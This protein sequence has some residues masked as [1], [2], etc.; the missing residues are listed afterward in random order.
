MEMASG[1]QFTVLSTEKDDV[2]IGHAITV[3]DWIDLRDGYSASTKRWLYFKRKYLWE[4]ILGC[5]LLIPACP[6]I[7]LLCIL[8]RLNSKGNALY[9]QTRVGFRGKT[10]EIY[11][12][13]TMRCD[14]E[15]DGEARWCQKNDERITPLGRIIRKLHLDE[16]P[17]LFNVAQGDMT[18][19][20]PRPERPVF[21]DRLKL[22]ISGYER[23]LSVLPG[24]T[25]LAQINLPPD[26][27]TSDVRRKLY[28]DL[29]YIDGACFWLDFRML[30][31]SSVRL[32][33]VPGTIVTHLLGLY[34]PAPV[35]H[36]PSD[37][38]HPISLHP[39]SA[40]IEQPTRRILKNRS[41]VTT[42]RIKFARQS[43]DLP[44]TSSS[45][46]TR[47]ADAVPN[48]LTVDVEDY[49]QVSAFEHRIARNK[50]GNFESRVEEN[51]DRLLKLFDE[52]NVHGTFFV[53]GWI[54]DHYP[55]L[56][57]RIADAGHEIGCHSYDHRLVY[58]ISPG[59]FREDLQK[60]REAIRKAC[61]IEVT[62]YRAP[63]FSITSKSLFAIGTL[64]EEG[65]T[66]DS[67]VFPMKHDRYGMPDAIPDVHHLSV[68]DSKLVEFP[69][70]VWE[71]P[72][73]K[74]PIGGGYFR[75]SPYW[76]TSRAIQGVR[77]AGRPAMFY[78]HPWEIDPAQPTIANVGLKS[79]FR[80]YVGQKSTLDKLSR[81]LDNHSFAPISEVLS[82]EVMSNTDLEV[83]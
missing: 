14:A 56:I 15:A 44:A 10:F 12:I 66:L 73:G 11:K 83:A 59:Q 70:S 7:L 64:V 39:I 4:R 75:L 13:R 81:L 67:S 55:A 40:L 46:P 79:H 42:E 30:M 53:L 57:K 6:V 27:T 72:I 82:Y 21:V 36:V 35:F 41:Q 74:I 29:K 25:G 9:K 71:S 65:F 49:F 69:P 45:T 28:L 20:G 2:A 31:A 18:L 19:V 34:R 38:L 1:T 5:I 61:G 63:S 54:A 50:W 80:H 43:S 33:G 24:I 62:S 3:E 52:K 58:E 16:L 60:S 32:L 26:T 77:N 68:S 23:R 51:T 22:I 47:L 37:D 8:V 78:V 76:V 17:Q 48:A